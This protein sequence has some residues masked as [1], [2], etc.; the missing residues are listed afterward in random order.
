[1]EVR[2]YSVK[3]NIQACNIRVYITITQNGQCRKILSQVSKKFMH[4]AG[5]FSMGTQVQQ[6]AL[7]GLH[8][9]L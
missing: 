2:I 5:K 9:C 8:I 3:A 6:R 4:F 7:L 1:M